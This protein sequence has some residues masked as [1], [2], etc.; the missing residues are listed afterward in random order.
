MRQPVGDAAALRCPEPRWQALNL[1][2]R[3]GAGIANVGW[4][5]GKSCSS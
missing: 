3:R 4:P 5:G 1:S 2:R